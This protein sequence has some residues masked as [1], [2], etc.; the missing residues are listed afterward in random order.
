ML[1]NKFYSPTKQAID[2][3]SI[4]LNKKILCNEQCLRPKVF[5]HFLFLPCKNILYGAGEKHCIDRCVIEQPSS[6]GH[7]ILP[8]SITFSL[9]FLV[10]M[11]LHACLLV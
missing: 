2:N 5:K 3:Q 7:Q 1:N 10:S 4:E 11:N 6:P 8:T 9:M